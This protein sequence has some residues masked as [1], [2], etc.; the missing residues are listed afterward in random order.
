M[1]INNVKNKNNLIFYITI[2]M[3]VVVAIISIVVIVNIW[4]G[5]SKNLMATYTFNE[6][7]YL[8]KV[9]RNY[10]LRMS[11]I[12]VSNNFATLEK[13][14]DNDYLKSVG[15]ENATSD[16]KKDYLLKNNIIATSASNLVIS[17]YEVA[18]GVENTYVYRYAYQVGGKAKYFNLIEHEPYDYT[19]S[20]EQ[21]A[22]P[23]ISEVYVDKIIDDID[24]EIST[25]ASLST[26]VR[27]NAKITNNSNDTI[28]FDFNS[29]SKVAVYLEDG[30]SETLAG[31]V[32]VSEDECTLKPQSFLNKTLEFAIPFSRQSEI[33]KIVFYSVEVGDTTKNIEIDLKK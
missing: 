31:I 2:A 15:L 5:S 1:D 26:V 6:D 21:D 13:I 18:K 19:I 20:F 16:E 22:I 14:L 30:S 12:L 24:F 29:I 23:S 8:D 10:Q 28:K 33:Q 27:F 4:T 11:S 9:A 25:E 7:T 17:N 3:I 32:T